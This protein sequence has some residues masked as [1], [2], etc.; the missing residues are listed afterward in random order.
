[1]DK[2]EFKMNGDEYEYEE[3]D[4]TTGPF[5]NSPLAWPP[6]IRK[7]WAKTTIISAGWESLDRM[8]KLKK[9]AKRRSS[10]IAETP[11]TFGGRIKVRHVHI[12]NTVQLN[13][14][15]C[16]VPTPKT[17]FCNYYSLNTHSPFIM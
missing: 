3:D 10:R 16:Y 5:P 14:P 2:F 8:L 11:R 4:R 9:D 15:S 13:P 6:S 12:N 1:M 17:R 7:T